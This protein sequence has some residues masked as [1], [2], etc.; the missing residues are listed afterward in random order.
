MCVGVRD[1]FGVLEDIGHFLEQNTVL[2]LDFSET[3]YED[4]KS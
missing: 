1:A 4:I 3:L 2:T